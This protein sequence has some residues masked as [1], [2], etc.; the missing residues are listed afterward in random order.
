MTLKYYKCSCCSKFIVLI[1]LFYSTDVKKLKTL[2]MIRGRHLR[3]HRDKPRYKLNFTIV[4][5]YMKHT[6]YQS[7]WPPCWYITKISFLT[8][9]NSESKKREIRVSVLLFVIRQLPHYE[10][11]SCDFTDFHETDIMNNNLWII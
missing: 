1:T 9:S 7:A 5:I 2:C 4:E 8:M 11:A 6:I 10:H 3:N